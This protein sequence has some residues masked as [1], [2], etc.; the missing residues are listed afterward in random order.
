VSNTFSINRNKVKHP[1]LLLF[2]PTGVGKTEIL[3]QEFSSGYEVISADS[4]QVYRGL[5][6]GTAKPDARE[7][8]AVPHH[9]ID[10][11]EP[12]EQFQVGD[13]V[14]LADSCM[15]AVT[16]RGNIP[17]LSGGTA[18]YFKHFLFGLPGT[19]KADADL[20]RTLQA[21][22]EREGLPR[23]FERLKQRDPE[24]ARRISPE[25]AHRILRALEVYDSSGR[26]L[27]AYRIRENIREHIDPVT[28]GLW[29]DQKDLH[30]RIDRRVR[31]MFA[32]G[33]YQE[34]QQ[35]LSQGA[36]PSWP[37]MKGIGYREFFV[38]RDSGEQSLAM[39][40]REIAEN[41]KR[42]AKQQM[43][44]FRNLPGVHWLHPDERKAIRSLAPGQ[45]H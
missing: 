13:F 4:M 38:F 8:S 28:I 31:C 12:F 5:D 2:G 3:I 41:S 44:F 42:Y 34:L 15:Q 37:G 43:T 19:P 21:E 39:L 30:A 25:D 10:I 18:Y 40:A 16:R 24:S 14:R 20:R 26:P 29:R 6:I 22:L 11:R 35:L 9:L 1:V 36:S 32:E 33:L 7:R 27:S 45:E 17:I 23:M